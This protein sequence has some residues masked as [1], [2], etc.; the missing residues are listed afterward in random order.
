MQTALDFYGSMYLLYS[1]YDGATE[2]E[3]VFLQF[4]SHMDRFIARMGAL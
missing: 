4:E 1:V 2:K 3:A